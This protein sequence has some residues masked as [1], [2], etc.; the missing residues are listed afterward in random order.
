MLVS[1][2]MSAKAYDWRN[3]KDLNNVMAPD[4]HFAGN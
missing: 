3:G 4:F 2:R 1:K